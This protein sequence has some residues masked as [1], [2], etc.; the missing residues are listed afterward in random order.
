LFRIVTDGTV[1]SSNFST[2]GRHFLARREIDL[3][4]GRENVQSSA[5]NLTS[6]ASN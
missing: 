5:V 6:Q 3:L 2:A 4:D 1:R